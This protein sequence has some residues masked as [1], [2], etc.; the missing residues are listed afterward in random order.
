MT[1]VSLLLVAS[2]PAVASAVD[3][4]VLDN[5]DRISG[6]LLRLNEGM[7][8]FET[9]YAGTIRVGW[10]HV[11]EIRSDGLLRVCLNGDEVFGVSSLT[12]EGDSANLDGRKEPVINITQ[13][14]PA[15]WELGKASRLSGEIDAALKLDRGNTHDDV[16]NVAGRFE[17]KKRKHRIRLGGEVEYDQNGPSVVNDRWS[18]ETTYDNTNSHRIY[19]GERSSLRSDRMANLT[20]L[21]STGPYIGYHII[22]TNRTRLSTETGIEYTDENYRTLPVETFL[23]ESWRIEFSHFLIPGKLEIYHRNKGLLNLSDI[24]GLLFDTWSGVKF[25]ITSNL[26]TSAEIKTAFNSAA[27]ANAIPWDTSYRIRIGYHW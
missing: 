9:G 2:P 8:E 20:L 10:P 26:N 3:T 1:L 5:G 4:L 6:R 7:I 14:N 21:W 25:P 24:K 17:W 16:T 18:A 22:E 11:R 27:S 12:R 23:S 15:D 19:F 13:L